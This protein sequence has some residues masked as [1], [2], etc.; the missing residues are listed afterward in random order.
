[1]KEIL[2]AFLVPHLLALPV[3]LVLLSKRRNQTQETA[4]E[5]TEKEETGADIRAILFRAYKGLKDAKLGCYWRIVACIREIDRGGVVDAGVAAFAIKETERDT[6]TQPCLT[7]ALS[8][9]GM[10]E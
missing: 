4:P 10:G 8:E 1:M 6:G 9:L 5:S 3:Y 2:I 7:L